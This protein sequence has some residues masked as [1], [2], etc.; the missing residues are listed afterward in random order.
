MK[1]LLKKLIPVL[2]LTTMLVACTDESG[3]N[4][5][6]EL[7]SSAALNEIAAMEPAV[8]GEEIYNSFCLAC[9]A[10]GPGNA[11]TMRLAMRLGKEKSVLTQREDLNAVY[12]KTIVRQ[13]IMLM[14]PFR[15]SE[16]TD[17]ELE[18]LATY[19]AK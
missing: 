11:G 17:S 9:H 19:L 7:S 2:L 4:R 5:Q 8:D 10:A 12:V 3:E 1:L 16:I 6:E 15:P 14:P 18:A 13:G